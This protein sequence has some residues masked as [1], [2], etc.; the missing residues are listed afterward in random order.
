MNI[1]IPDDVV[2][3]SQVSEAE[4]RLELAVALYQAQKVTLGQAAK[5]AALPQASFLQ[6]LGR[7]HVAVNY[8]VDDLAADL[9]GMADRSRK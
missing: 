3:A 1:T 8:G 4:M 5:V 7:R 9:K 6:E 2:K